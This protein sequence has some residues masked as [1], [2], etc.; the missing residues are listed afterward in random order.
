MIETHI[1]GL[2]DIVSFSLVSRGCGRKLMYIE[3]EN[4]VTDFDQCTKVDL[5]PPTLHLEGT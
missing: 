2:S 4:P 3:H 5:V 1:E